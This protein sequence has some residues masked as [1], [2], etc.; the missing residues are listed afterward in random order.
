MILELRFNLLP[1][2][3]NEQIDLG[4]ALLERRRMTFR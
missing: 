4:A 1:P 2:A 3:L